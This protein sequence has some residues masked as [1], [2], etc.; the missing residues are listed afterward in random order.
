M[1]GVCANALAAPPPL[2]ENKDRFEVASRAV[3]IP[4]YASTGAAIPATRRTN[5]EELNPCPRVS[6][7]AAR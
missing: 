4:L 3:K 7:N 1:A 2:L 6:L 5:V